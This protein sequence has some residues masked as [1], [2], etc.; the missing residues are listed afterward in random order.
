[1]KKN[2]SEILEIKPDKQPIGKYAEAKPFTTHEIDL[3]KGD[4]F[5]IFTD[6]FAD[7][8]GGERGKKFKASSMKELILAIQTY[9]MPEQKER[10]NESFETWRGSLEQ[11]DDVSVIGVRV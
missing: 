9:S 11:I 4:T 5:Y 8:F 6:G 2:S 7:Q 3:A 10:L 1:M